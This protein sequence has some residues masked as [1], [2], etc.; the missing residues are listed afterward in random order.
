MNQG[1]ARNDRKVWP[2]AEIAARQP[3]VG[4]PERVP[5]KSMPAI[6]FLFRFRL[7]FLR[8]VNEED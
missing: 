1:R 2:T 5:K 3:Q 6:F 8:R 7:I 4:H